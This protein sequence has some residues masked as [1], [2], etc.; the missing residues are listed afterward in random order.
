[1]GRCPAIVRFPLITPLV[2]AVRTF[3]HRCYAGKG[4][5]RVVVSTFTLAITTV[6][7]AGRFCSNIVNYLIGLQYI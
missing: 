1:M 3:S 6:T 4:I 2:A 7:T 5:T